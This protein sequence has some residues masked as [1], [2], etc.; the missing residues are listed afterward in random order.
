MEEE[1]RKRERENKTLKNVIQH[2]EMELNRWRNGKDEGGVLL[3]SPHDYWCPGTLGKAWMMVEFVWLFA[4]RV[5]KQMFSL[6]LIPAPTLSLDWHPFLVWA[7]DCLQAC[8]NLLPSRCASIRYC[9]SLSGSHGLRYRGWWLR[10]WG[11]DCFWLMKMSFS[12]L[13]VL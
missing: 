10:F 2:L 9:N 13:W 4:S 11:F 8:L 7:S 5:N 12:P 6:A 3:S 1:I